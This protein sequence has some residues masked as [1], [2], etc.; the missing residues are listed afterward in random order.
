MSNMHSHWEANVDTY[1][2]M[3]STWRRLKAN[4]QAF[5][6]ELILPKIQIKRGTD[7]LPDSGVID[8]WGRN[9]SSLW[10]AEWSFRFKSLWSPIKDIHLGGALFRLTLHGLFLP[11]WRAVFVFITLKSKRPQ[12]CSL[13]SVTV[14]WK[15]INLLEQWWKP[16]SQTSVL[17]SQHKHLNLPY[18]EV[19]VAAQR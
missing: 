7:S 15:H 17:I 13:V 8:Y 10:A 12:T 9:W 18:V 3:S 1:A 6:T 14:P 16:L 11:T 4:S 5:I 19:P 2:R